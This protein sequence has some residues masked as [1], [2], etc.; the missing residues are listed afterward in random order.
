MHILPYETYYT[1][2]RQCSPKL[3]SVASLSTYIRY[4]PASTV[5]QAVK[6][7]RGHTA[8]IGSGQ[9]LLYHIAAEQLQAESR[10]SRRLRREDLRVVVKTPWTT[11]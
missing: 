3:S 8:D 10:T 1:G 7:N 11:R 9:A 5:L 6:L 4:P 2:S